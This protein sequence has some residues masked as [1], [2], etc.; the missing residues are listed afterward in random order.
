MGGGRLGLPASADRWY[1]GDM[2]AENLLTSRSRLTGVL[3]FGG[4]GVGDPSVDPGLRVGAAGRPRPRGVPHGAGRR[5]RGV[6]PWPGLGAGP[7][8][9]DPGYYGRTMPQRCAARLAMGR[10]VLSEG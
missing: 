10:A 9:D 7:G 4:L 8:R 1:H 2:V 3:D 5:R 6:G